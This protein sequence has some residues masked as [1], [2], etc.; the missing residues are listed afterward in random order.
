MAAL[1]IASASAR[2]LCETQL[3]ANRARKTLPAEQAK[4]WRAVAFN[5]AV[6]GAFGYL[7]EPGLP[8]MR[9]TAKSGNYCADIYPFYFSGEGHAPE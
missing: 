6:R 5:L 2:F 4:G 7:T 9:T 8:P 3:I 1:K